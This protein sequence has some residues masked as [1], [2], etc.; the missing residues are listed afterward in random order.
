[1]ECILESDIMYK[2]NLVCILRP[3]VKKGIIIRT[4][5]ASSLNIK[6]GFS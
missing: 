5:Y 3:E 4:E 6:L 2:D 1:M